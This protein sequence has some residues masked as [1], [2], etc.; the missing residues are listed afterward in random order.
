MTPPPG[1]VHLTS[2]QTVS[3]VDSVSFL[4]LGVVGPKNLAVSPDTITWVIVT[5]SVGCH[6]VTEYTRHNFEGIESIWKCKELYPDAPSFEHLEV[7]YTPVQDS[8]H[9]L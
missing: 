7:E 2:M 3:D 9:S 5:L 8:Y 6:G 4:Q 1:P